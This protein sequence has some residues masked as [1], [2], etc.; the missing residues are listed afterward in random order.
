MQDNDL[1]RLVGVQPQQNVSDQLFHKISELIL[2]G[3]LPEGYAFPNETVLCEQLQVGRTTLREAY[4]ALELSGYVTRTKR[5]TTVNSRTTILNATP[6][7]TAFSQASSRDF[8]E[9]RLMLES[10]SASLA[11]NRISLDEIHILEHCMELSR[12]A[13]DNEDYD[14]LMQLDMRFH[15]QIADS[16][17]NAL[18]S[19]TITVMTETWESVIQR[20]FIEGLQNNRGVF[21]QALAQHKKILEAL[22][23]RD[24]AAARREMSEHIASVTNNNP[25]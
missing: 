11:A 9:F 16:S 21:E 13:L 10:E 2:S 1:S 24:C 12:E 17:Q 3:Q 23:T 6:L 14:E 15:R 5:G 7:K 8:N 18:V 4:K 25:Q 20:N 22:R 19:T